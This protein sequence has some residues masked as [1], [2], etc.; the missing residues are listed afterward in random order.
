MLSRGTRQATLC[1]KWPQTR[2]FY[3]KMFK[4]GKVERRPIDAGEDGEPS[5]LHGGR[6]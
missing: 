6:N 4:D 2:R 1:I 3:P 5:D